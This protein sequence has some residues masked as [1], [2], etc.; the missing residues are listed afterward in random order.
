MAGE[1]IIIA[2]FVVNLHFN[3]KFFIQT[4]DV[5]LN[6]RFIVILS[7]IVLCWDI[8]NEN[9]QI[10]YILV[11]LV[12]VQFWKFLPSLVA[13]QEVQEH[14]VAS[15]KKRR[16]KNPDVLSKSESVFVCLL[17]FQAT[18]EQRFNVIFCTKM[19]GLLFIPGDKSINFLCQ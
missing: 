1:E 4:P 5:L 19:A 15:V 2:N 13:L 6:K 7:E 14:K 16:E 18:T 3:I 17:I 9:L 8:K 10:K 11:Y 12:D